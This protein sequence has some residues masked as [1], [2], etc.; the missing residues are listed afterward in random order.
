MKVFA[1]STQ[2]RTHI[3]PYKYCYALADYCLQ[4]IIIYFVFISVHYDKC[5]EIKDKADEDATKTRKLDT[6]WKKTV[7]DI[8][9]SA[10]DVE[11]S[12]S[13]GDEPE[14]ERED[15]TG[16]DAQLSSDK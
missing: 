8:S 14:I 10:E 4:L 11:D 13:V 6:F 5:K 2:V 16:A 12:T 7:S 9:E 3:V 1:W 15:F